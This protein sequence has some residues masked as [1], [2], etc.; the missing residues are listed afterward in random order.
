MSE[1]SH[2]H[3]RQRKV[4]AACE[5]ADI[6][7]VTVDVYVLDG[8]TPGSEVR[9]VS[10]RGFRRALGDGANNGAFGR[11]L[12]RLSEDSSGFSMGPTYEFKAPSSGRAV[13]GIEVVKIAEY[14]ATIVDQ[15]L[16]GVLHHSRERFVERARQIE[17]NLTKLALIALVD[18]ATGYQTARQPDALREL[19]R[20]YM[21]DEP[22]GWER[23][24]PEGLYVLAARLYGYVYREGQKEKPAFLR[25]WTWRY[26]YAF[27]PPEVREEIQR[28]NHD[29]H[30]HGTKHHQHLTPVIREV[31]RLHA[32]ALVDVLVQSFNPADFKMRFE[33]RFKNGPLQGSLFGS[34]A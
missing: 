1:D 25:S 19:M 28:V 20:A 4:L 11:S 14:A 17:K 32:N 21:L 12:T 5:A 18:E 6:L 16:D 26:V 27:L 29:P 23:A 15:K 7:G 3:P 10:T 30:L 13:Q 2:K 33:R 24:I 31:L 9:V 8:A 34:A 22:M